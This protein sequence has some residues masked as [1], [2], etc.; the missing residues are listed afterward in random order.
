M[1]SLRDGL[2]SAG[3]EVN[4]PLLAGHGTSASDLKRMGWEDWYQ[5]VYG[6]Y[7]GLVGPGRHIFVAGQ[8]LGALLGLWLAINEPVRIAGLACL[9]TSLVLP[10]F[11]AKFFLPVLTDTPL[12]HLYQYQKKWLGGAISDPEAQA[13][14]ARM[15]YDKLPISG[16]RSIQK[17]QGLV[18]DRLTE[19]TTPLLLVHSVKDEAAPYDCMRIVKDRVS[20]KNVETLTLEKSNHVLTMDYEKDLVREKV[21]DFFR[22]LC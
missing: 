6:A 17:L 4:A 22:R 12:K 20:S 18:W 10:G 5:T 9:A 2:M 3:F 1:K 21:V 7:R 14:H 16:V 15:S 19:V 11:A 8:S 13:A